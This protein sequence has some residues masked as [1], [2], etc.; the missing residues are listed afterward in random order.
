VVEES[1]D[2]ETAGGGWVCG[3]EG[4]EALEAD[5]GFCGGR[6]A[7]EDGG[8]G[9]GDEGVVWERGE[10]SGHGFGGG[11]GDAAVGEG[12]GLLRGDA[13]AASVAF[14]DTGVVEGT[15]EAVFEFAVLLEVEGAAVGGFL[16]RDGDGGAAEGEVECAGEGEDPVPDCLGFETFGVHAPEEGVVRVSG[17]SVVAIGGG[18]AA[19]IGSGED[20][21]AEERLEFPAGLLERDG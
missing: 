21:R 6:L 18:G 11:A 5:L 14:E 3:G 19:E 12:E 16:L 9:G 4:G 20:D 17:E 8:E 1:E 7:G 15:E 2:E 13:F 10:G